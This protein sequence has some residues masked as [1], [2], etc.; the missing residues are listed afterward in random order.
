[1]RTGKLAE[2]TSDILSGIVRVA[3]LPL[4]IGGALAPYAFFSIVFG[5]GWERTGEIVVYMVPWIVMQILVSPISM[6]LHTT[7]NQ[8]TALALQLFGLVLRVGVVSAVAATA[9]GYLTEV[10]SFTG[11]VFYFVYLLVV[12]KVAG[13]S[14]LE[15]FRRNPYVL[16]I[17]VVVY[18][19]QYIVKA[20]HWFAW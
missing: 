16:L 2:F 20:N 7:N 10:Y 13:I 19:A 1:M 17:A 14:L 15:V 8:P 12:L 4:V 18:L 3:V 11:F 6:V 5:E 9:P